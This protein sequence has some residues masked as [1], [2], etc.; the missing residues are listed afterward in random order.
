M[1]LPAYSP[2]VKINICLA[3]FL[4]GM[5]VYF[6]SFQPDSDV[7]HVPCIHE[8]RTGQPCPTCGL[9]R[10]FSAIIRFDAH[11][12][13]QWNPFS[14]HLF[15]FF[16]LQW[17]LRI[18]FMLSAHLLKQYEKRIAFTDILLSTCMFLAAFSP[19]ILY[20]FRF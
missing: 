12:A 1:N 17:I 10:S 16:F 2:Y 13:T 8:I 5:L 3:I 9:S 6:V 4:T 15:L 20:M 19:L 18:A 7:H 11:Q 14:P